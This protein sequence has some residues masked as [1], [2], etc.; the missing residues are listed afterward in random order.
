VEICLLKP[1][2]RFIYLNLLTGGVQLGNTNI[3]GLCEA[4]CL[5]P[6]SLSFYHSFVIPIQCQAI[7]NHQ[8]SN[9]DIGKNR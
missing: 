8:D 9:P 6:D 7:Q 5:K 3:S 2:S 4:F 1:I